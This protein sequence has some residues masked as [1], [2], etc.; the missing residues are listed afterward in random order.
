MLVSFYKYQG[1]GNDFIL[2]DNR[3]EIVSALN[4]TLI[5]NLC[6]RKFGI[7]ADGLVLLRNHSKYDFEMVYYN[8]D[9]SQSLCANGSRCAVHLA[10]YLGIIQDHTYFLTTDGPHQA[11]IRNNLIWLQLQEVKLMQQLATDYFVDIGSPH[12]I[13]IVDN[14][15]E[16][17]VATL[18]KAL[19]NQDAFKKVGTNVNFVKLEANNRLTVR[20][21]E[22]GVEAET[23]SCGTGVTA[24]AL[25]AATKGY[26]S[27]IEVNTLGGN[28]T[29]HFT[30]KSP[31]FSNIYLVGPAVMVFQGTIEI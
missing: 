8:A 4:A 6:H 1:T 11:F 26:T 2:I 18:G 21:Y 29:V 23:L 10:H 30:G 17:D 12:Y 3:Q 20:T 27:P 13:R 22:R 14:V 16:L 5:Q 24:A 28:L 15:A 31:E 19:R 9:S 25:I 7:G